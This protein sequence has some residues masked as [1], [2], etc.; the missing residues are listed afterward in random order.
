MLSLLK[1]IL[2]CS[3]YGAYMSQETMTEDQRKLKDLLSV[4]CTC[5]AHS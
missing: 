5:A 1:D 2:I 3:V 4:I